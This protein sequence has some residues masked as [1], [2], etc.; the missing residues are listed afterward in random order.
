MKTYRL[1]RGLALTH[2]LMGDGEVYLELVP[3]LIIGVSAFPVAAG[4]G[5]RPVRK[6]S[7]KAI[8]M[9]SAGV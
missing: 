9:I 7:L 6:T 8:T 5:K 3:S 1:G 2:L 4:T